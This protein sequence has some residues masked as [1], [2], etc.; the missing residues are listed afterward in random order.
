M[1]PVRQK[2]VII[3]QETLVLW[4]RSDRLAQ[5]GSQAPQTHNPV[6]YREAKTLPHSRFNGDLKK[7]NGLYQAHFDPIWKLERAQQTTTFRLRTGQCSLRVCLKRTGISD[8][9][10]VSADR[11]TKP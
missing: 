3:T 9:S 10:P 1:R 11:L 4:Y 8:T 2:Q 7:D 6:T 5:I